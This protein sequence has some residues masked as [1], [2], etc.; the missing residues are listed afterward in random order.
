MFRRSLSA[1]AAVLVVVLAACSP[2]G[3]PNQ[4][5]PNAST[6]TLSAAS[7]AVVGD[8]GVTVTVQLSDAGGDRVALAGQPVM[9]EAPGGRLQAKGVSTAA[10]GDGGSITVLTDE[11]GQAVAQFVSSSTGTFQIYAYLGSKGSGNRIGSVSVTFASSTGGNGGGGS[12]TGGDTDAD[13]GGDNGGD[14]NGDN[15]GDTTGDQPGD[16]TPA[17]VDASASTFSA[18]V[19]TAAVGSNVLLTVQ[20]K[21]ADG[22]VITR[23]GEPVTFTS[24]NGLQIGRAHV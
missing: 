23:A 19:N 17:T 12:N 5:T 3:G 11:N 2:N 10:T 14:E 8:T 15:G 1:I 4:P 9:F 6:S 24:A 18:A 13:N 16:P 7:T 21:D 20:I 22:K